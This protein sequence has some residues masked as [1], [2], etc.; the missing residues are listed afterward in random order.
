ML[1]D[2]Q[3]YFRGTNAVA[4]VMDTNSLAVTTHSFSS[5]DIKLYAAPRMSCYAGCTDPEG[6]NDVEND[7]AVSMYPNPVT[8]GSF[9]IKTSGEMTIELVDLSGRVVLTA[10]GKDELTIVV[11]ALPPSVYGVK[12]CS[13]DKVRIEKIVLVK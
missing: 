11:A 8:N 7:Q 3:L 9:T 2:G 4:Y 12:I 5:A 6:M 10:S 1:P 13:A